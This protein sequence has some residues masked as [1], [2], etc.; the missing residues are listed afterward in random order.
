MSLQVF[1]AGSSSEPRP[2]RLTPTSF[3]TTLAPSLAIESANSRPMP[4]PDPVMTATRPSSIPIGS[5]GGGRGAGEDLGPVLVR[6]GELEVDE[7]LPA[8]LPLADDLGRE[9]ERVA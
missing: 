6:G 9:R 8:L 2:S 3:T 7:L 4:R 5:G 1:A